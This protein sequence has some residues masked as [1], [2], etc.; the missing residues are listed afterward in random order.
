MS[1]RTYVKII[2]GTDHASKAKNNN[3]LKGAGNESEADL[4]N[5]G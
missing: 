2:R 4:Q 3:F 1:V 5:K